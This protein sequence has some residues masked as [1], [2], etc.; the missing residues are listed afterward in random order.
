MTLSPAKATE[1]IVMPFRK[2]SPVGQRNQIPT[3]KVAILRKKG[4]DWSGALP[5]AE[6]TSPKH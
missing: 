1:P 3:C 4:L 5:I 6:A 2:M